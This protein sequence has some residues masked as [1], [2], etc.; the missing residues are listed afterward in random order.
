MLF[1]ALIVGVF[2]WY[3]TNKH[4]SNSNDEF[5]I[6]SD[7]RVVIDGVVADFSKIRYQSL[8][9]AYRHPSIHFHDF[10][11]DVIHWHASRKDLAYFFSAIGLQLTDRCISYDKSVFCEQ[12][13]KA[14]RIFVNDKEVYD[15][16]TYVPNDLDRILI[17]YGVYSQDDVE[18][19]LAQVTDRACIQSE[20]CP[21]RGMPSD[22]ASCAGG[23]GSGCGAV[24]PWRG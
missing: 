16:E 3:S 8:K 23:D 22:A 10:D 1:V 18:K 9:N 4:D 17:L 5:H 7:L 11:G 14:L 12:G 21:E 19:E 13:N 2:L 15:G 24:V 6:H 20:I